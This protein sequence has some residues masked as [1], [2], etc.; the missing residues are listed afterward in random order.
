[1]TAVLGF[2]L[3][4]AAVAAVVGAVA[5]LWVAAMVGAWTRHGAWP[6]LRADGA[7]V[8]GILPAVVA[9]AAVA[10]TAAPALSAVVGWGQD[11]CGGHDHHLHLCFLHSSGGRPVLA[12][13]GAAALAMFVFRAGGLVWR[14]LHTRSRLAALEALGSP[15]TGPFPVVV[16]PGA[17]RVCHAAGVL[18]RRVLVSG[19][20]EEVLTAEQLQGVLAHEEAHL[21]RQD[22]LASL[23]LCASGLFVPPPLARRFLARYQLAAEQAC[24]AEA[25]HVVGDGAVM[26][27]ALVKMAALQR[28]AREAAAVPAFGQLALEARVRALLGDEPLQA[29]ASRA[30]LLGAGVAAGVLTLALLHAGFLHHAVETALHFIS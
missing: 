19:S 25:V 12:V 5:S 17:P 30:L 6:A 9:L 21:R 23:L 4:C 22:P 26:A 16:V 28:G 18:R 1:M 3:E 11:H 14:I 15:R 7:F 13:A 8:L 24:D 10:A 27:E 2:I 20:L 29:R